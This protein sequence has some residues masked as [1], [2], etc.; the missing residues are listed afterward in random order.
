MFMQA[1]F[2]LLEVGFSRAKNAGAGVAKVLVNFSI[3]SL[4]YW[5]CRLRAGVRRAR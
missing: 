2:L 4:C 3:A 5:A 1:G